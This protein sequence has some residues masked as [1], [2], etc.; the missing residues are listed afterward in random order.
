M[1]KL[2]I[3]SA[4][5][6]ALSSCTSKKTAEST[7]SGSV[8]GTYGDSTFVDYAAWSGETLIDTLKVRDSVYAKVN[9]DIKAV[10]QAKGCWMTLSA[11]EEEVFVKFKDYSFFVPMNSAGYNATMLGWAKKDVVSVKDQ[12]EYAKDA[13]KSAEEI[14]KITSPRVD[15]TFMAEG[16]VIRDKEEG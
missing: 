10:C 16:V 13:D 6:F 14:A 5:L 4:I 1:K 12:I 2:I 3:F 15:Y 11:G 8:A 9:G 7:E